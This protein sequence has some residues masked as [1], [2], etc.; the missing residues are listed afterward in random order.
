LLPIARQRFYSRRFPALRAS[1][2]GESRCGAERSERGGAAFST[3]EAGD[4]PAARNARQRKIWYGL[5]LAGS[6][7]A[8][9]D[10]WSTYRAVSG[11]YGRE[12]NPFLRP[13]ANSK[14]SMRRRK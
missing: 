10:A 2:Q 1:T 11:G 3:D 8:A 14:R 5:A 9:F 7:G 4:Y 12:A 6:S 13:F